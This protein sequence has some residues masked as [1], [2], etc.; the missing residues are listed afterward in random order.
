MFEGYANFLNR[1]L[2]Q[3]SLRDMHFA[4]SSHDRRTGARAERWWSILATS[5][6]GS[7]TGWSSRWSRM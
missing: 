4:E 2:Q 6:P 5:V 1:S 7:T 3:T